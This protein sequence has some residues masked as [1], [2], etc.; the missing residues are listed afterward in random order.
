MKKIMYMLDGKQRPVGTPKCSSYRNKTEGDSRLSSFNNEE[1][2]SGFT[3]LEIEKWS[4]RSDDF[5]KENNEN[6][7]LSDRISNMFSKKHRD[8]SSNL[9]SGSSFNESNASSSR[10]GFND[11]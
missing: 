3:V 4:D 6:I 10:T 11:N 9:N 5:P 2:E 1:S 7:D 8:S